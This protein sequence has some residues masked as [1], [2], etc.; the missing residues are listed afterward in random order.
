MPPQHETQQLFVRAIYQLKS[1]KS[2]MDE[3]ALD[4]RIQS[5]TSRHACDLR[6]RL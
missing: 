1:G 6:I 2:P 3:N 4:V 5:V